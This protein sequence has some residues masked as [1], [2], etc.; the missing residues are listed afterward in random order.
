MKKFHWGHGIALF[1]S[2]FAFCMIFAVIKSTSFDNSLVTKDYYAKDIT[3]QNAHNSKLNSKRLK[4]AVRVDRRAS[5]YVLVLPIEEVGNN[6]SGDI[7]L[8]SPVSS[9]RDLTWKLKL[10]QSGEQFIPLE[11]TI[12]GR[13]RLIVNWTDGK[14]QYLDELPLYLQS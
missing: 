12:S 2:T 6:I 11:N 7:Q 4:Q 13:Y 5:G 8:Y 1:Y 3:Y 10:D 14:R 9:R